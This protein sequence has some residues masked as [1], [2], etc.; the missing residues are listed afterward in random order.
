MHNYAKM[1]SLRFCHERGQIKRWGAVRHVIVSGI[2]MRVF[3]IFIFSQKNRFSDVWT[4]HVLLKLKKKTSWKPILPNRSDFR[5]VDVS[6]VFYVFFKQKI[7]KV[8]QKCLGPLRDHPRPIPDHFGPI[9]TKNRLNNYITKIPMKN[10]IKIIIIRRLY[11]V[12]PTSH[13]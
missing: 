10:H 8:P 12:F 13:A 4:F 11:C 3:F 2:S 9:L 6:Y 5:H 1:S 7:P